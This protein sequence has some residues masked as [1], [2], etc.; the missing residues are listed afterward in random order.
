MPGPGR[1]PVYNSCMAFKTITIDTEAYELLSSKK[2]AGQSFSA[3]IKQEVKRGGTGR[4]LLEALEG[5][6][7]SEKTLDAIEQVIAA[8]RK[9]PARAPR[10]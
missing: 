7:V 9:S 4:D 3:V 2:K 8:R 6:K 1:P 5:L 10:L